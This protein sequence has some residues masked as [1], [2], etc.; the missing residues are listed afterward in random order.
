MNSEIV[1]CVSTPKSASF[2]PESGF[3][4]RGAAEAS[5]QAR[6]KSTFIN[7]YVLTIFLVVFFMS[8]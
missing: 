8:Q 7:T 1:I 6:T 4:S 2:L 5:K 3:S